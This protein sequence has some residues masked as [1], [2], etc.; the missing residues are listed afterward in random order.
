M[1][2]DENEKEN[3]AK[4]LIKRN[5]KVVA[6]NLKVSELQEMTDSHI[7]VLVVS[8]NPQNSTELLNKALSHIYNFQRAILKRSILTWETP[9]TH[10]KLRRTTQ[11]NPSKCGSN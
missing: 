3:M 11:V 2:Q 1:A 5:K 7:F 6:L 4:E 8:E 10:R 9:S